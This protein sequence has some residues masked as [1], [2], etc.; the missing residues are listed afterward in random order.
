MK[1]YFIRQSKIVALLC[2]FCFPF[3]SPIVYAADPL[4]PGKGYNYNSF[5]L[6]PGPMA[7]EQARLIT[8]LIQGAVSGS[9][10]LYRREGNQ[11]S[12]ITAW[13]V[14]SPNKDGDQIDIVTQD[15]IRHQGLI[16][17][18]RQIG[19]NDLGLITFDSQNN[20]QVAKRLKDLNTLEPGS[21]LGLSGFPIDEPHRRY[22]IGELV[23]YTDVGIGNGYELLYTNKTSAGMSGGPILSS[24]GLL[25]GIH[26]RGE[27]DQA[28]AIKRG[29]EQKTAV[30]QGMPIAQAD[31]S[32]KRAQLTPANAAKFLEMTKR[33]MKFY[34][35]ETVALKMV[36]R[37][38]D[39]VPSAEAFFVRGYINEDLH[40][41]DSALLAYQQATNIDPAHP[42]GFNHADL[43]AKQGMFA[44]AR[45]KLNA[46]LATNPPKRLEVLS[47]RTLSR[48]ATGEG[49]IG[50]AIVLA[51]KVVSAYP[52][53][54]VGYLAI[55]NA[56]KKAGNLEMQVRTLNRVLDVQPNFAFALSRRA[57]SYLQLGEPE[58]AIQ[59]ITK[60]INI[61]GFASFNQRNRLDDLGF[62]YAKRAM[63]FATIGACEGAIYDLDKAAKINKKHPGIKEIKNFIMVKC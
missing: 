4:L 16:A 47:W 1:N 41:Y 27:R 23:A 18:I 33:A 57:S 42:A 35:R 26:G 2:A 30:N 21:P 3:C 62:E 52:D 10:T 31:L 20:Y 9:G 59:D 15:G 17:S 29:I 51:E 53:S 50:E 39:K 54:N 28:A 46:Y 34:G 61:H 19:N 24:K 6:A 58:K 11:Y 5:T 14:I 12:V 48:I 55:Y 43:L 45:I 49:R 36:N 37:L 13:H 22:E 60:A 56:Y 7:E 63:A 25:V 38:I 32:I 8:V 40:Q 44:D